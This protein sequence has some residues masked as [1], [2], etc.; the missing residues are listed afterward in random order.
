MLI[1]TTRTKT[2]EHVLVQGPTFMSCY[3]FHAQGP[4]DG[5]FVEGWSVLISLIFRS[6]LDDSNCQVPMFPLSEPG[7]EMME[8]RSELCLVIR[9]NLS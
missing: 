7:S 8:F 5:S 4:F 3:S 9:L 1:L 6:C 2:F